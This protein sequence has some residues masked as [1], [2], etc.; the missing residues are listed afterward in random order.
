MTAKLPTPIYQ[1]AR[2]TLYCADCLDVMPLLEP[3]DVLFADPPYCSGGMYRGDRV[4]PVAYKYQLT[5]TKKTYASFAGDARDQRQFMAFMAS[6]LASANVVLGGIVAMY[7]DWRNL[8]ALW[9]AF[10][11][12][13]LVTRGI[14]CWDKTEGVRPTLGRPRQQAEF[15]VWG[16]NGPRPCAGNAVPG[17][18]RENLPGSKRTHQMQKPDSIAHDFAR[19]APDGGLVVDCFMGHGSSGVGAIRAGRRF[20]GIEI[21]PGHAA[22]AAERIARIEKEVA[23]G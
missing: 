23:D 4:Q 10:A 1:T 13:N 8:A 19:L 18:W 5:G 17:V 7:I 16:T 11:I 22:A 15:I 14:C 9:D 6:A 20:V 2:A 3:A 21:D 12:A